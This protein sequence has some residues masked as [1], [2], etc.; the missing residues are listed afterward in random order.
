MA[1]LEDG[2]RP[3]PAHRAASLG[4]LSPHRTPFCQHACKSCTRVLRQSVDV[5]GEDPILL[6]FHLASLIALLYM[7]D[8]EWYMVLPGQGVGL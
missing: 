1:C 5:R 6:G 3:S 8:D 4:R 7:L 2:G